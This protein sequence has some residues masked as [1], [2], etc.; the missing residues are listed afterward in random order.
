ME[1]ETQAAA[2]P[3]LLAAVVAV[4]RANRWSDGVMAGRLGVSRQTWNL[5]R[6]G[7]LALSAPTLGGVARLVPALEDGI[8]VYVRETAGRRAA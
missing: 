2:L 8:R 5:I 1:T 3:Q 4:Q 7:R 6:R